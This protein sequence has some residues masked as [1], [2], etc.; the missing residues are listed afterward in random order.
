MKIKVQMKIN[1]NMNPDQSEVAS[2]W[3]EVEDCIKFPV[4]VRRYM[5][6]DQKEKMFVTYPQRKKGSGYEG[7]V[8]PHDKVVRAEIEKN[9]LD[10]VW[11]EARKGIELPTVE[12]VRVSLLNP[13]RADSAIIARG[14]ATLRLAGM[15]ING[16]M[17]KESERGLFVQM[18]QHRGVDGIY[19]DTVYGTNVGIH[20]LIRDEVLQAYEKEMKHALKKKVSEQPEQKQPAKEQEEHIE[21]AQENQKAKQNEVLPEQKQDEVHPEQTEKS[22]SI[23]KIFQAYEQKDMPGMLKELQKAELTVEPAVFWENG[24]AVKSQI[25]VLEDAKRCIHVGFINTYNPLQQIP[26]DGYVK[27]ALQTNLFENGNC[28]GIQ[29]LSEEKSRSIKRAGENYQ[30]MLDRWTE[31]TKQDGIRFE[32]PQQQKRQHSQS[33]KE[34]L[35]VPGI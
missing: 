7:V 30:K 25:A 23:A 18:P 14:I 28:I 26:P 32:M 11:A 5:D 29:K 4:K 16:I 2:G 12:N 3:V 8:Y 13:Q 1:E 17:I 27:Q 6:K 34:V 35:P 21:P 15:T 22:S 9:V 31:I 10:A 24:N 20:A 33:H 19:K